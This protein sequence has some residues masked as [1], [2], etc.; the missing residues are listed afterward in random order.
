[1]LLDLSQMRE[2]RARIERAIEPSQFPAAGDE[3]YRV[4]APVDLAF[5]LFK[6]GRQFHLVGGLQTT[7]GLSCSRCLEEYTQPVGADFD[8]LYVPHVENTG[9]GEREIEDD[10]LTTAYYRDEQIDLGQLVREQLY[11]ALPMKPLCREQCRGLCPE[12]GTNL[13]TGDCA[14]AR[15]WADPRLAALKSLLHKDNGKV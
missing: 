1:M 7:L 4:E 2:A 10:D 11:L 12:C 14:C 15:E 9:E 8:L 3:A 5:D 6:D 13:N